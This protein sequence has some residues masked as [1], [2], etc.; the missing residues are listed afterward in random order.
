MQMFPCPFCG[1]RDEAEFSFGGEAGKARPEPA[2]AVSPETWSGFLYLHS[3]PRGFS[4]EIWLHASCGE[5]FLMERDTGDHAVHAS[6]SLRKADTTATAAAPH[7][8]EAFGSLAPGA[9]AQSGGA[10]A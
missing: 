4:R 10:P 6:H 3:N 2:G 9:Q 7:D 1:P 5:F 8:G